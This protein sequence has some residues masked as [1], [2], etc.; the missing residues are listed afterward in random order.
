[1][2]SPPTSTLPSNSLLLIPNKPEDPIRT[3]HK[4]F[5]DFLTDPERCRDKQF[6]VEPAVQHTEILFSC[7]NLMKARLKK[8]ICN[9]DDYTTLRE[10]KDLSA[11]K[12]NHIGDALEYACR[13]WTK[14][15][16]EI[17]GT[18]SC[19]QEVQKAI[20]IFFTTCLLYWIEVL[21]LTRNLGVGVYAINEIEQWY[22]LVSAV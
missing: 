6:L 15:L 11:Q 16:L 8:N 19:V 4:S 7:L 22:T 5:P 9:L 3:F 21:A 2:T 17:P 14:H 12:R 13:F 10:V 20:D 18:S 1:M